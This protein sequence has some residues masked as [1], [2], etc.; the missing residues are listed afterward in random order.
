MKFVLTL[1]NAYDLHEYL[2]D[3][4]QGEALVSSAY[5]FLA[6]QFAVGM[7]RTRR[8]YRDEHLDDTELLQHQ[9]FQV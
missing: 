8:R 9:P 5:P 1:E 7:T 4:V 2:N 6:S 3:L